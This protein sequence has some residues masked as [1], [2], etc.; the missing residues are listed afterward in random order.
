MS[1]LMLVPVWFLLAL[2]VPTFVVI[3]GHYQKVRGRRPTTCP[4]TGMGAMVEL[5]VPYAVRMRILGDGR[6]KIRACS[7]WPERATCGQ[8][9]GSR[10]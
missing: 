5:D 4:E 1:I 9:C 3:R 10:F 7:R 6:R 8:G 2:I